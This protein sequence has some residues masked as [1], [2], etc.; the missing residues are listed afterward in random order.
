MM[1]YI[2]PYHLYGNFIP[3]SSGKIAVFPKFP[4]PQFFLY[5]RIFREYHTGTYPLQHTHHLRNTVPWWKTQKN[6]YMICGY[7]LRV[8]LKSMMNRYLFKYLLNPCAYL[9]PQY[10]LPVFRCLYHMIFPIIH[11]MACSLQYHATCYTLSLIAFGKKLFIP[12]YKAE[13][14]SFNGSSDIFM[15]TYKI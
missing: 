7:L 5:L 2:F 4:S 11:C 8:Y 14:S 1:P 13:Y 15:G 9:S 10:P 12:A 6:M 3:N